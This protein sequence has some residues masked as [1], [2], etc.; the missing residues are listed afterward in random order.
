AKMQAAAD[1]ESRINQRRSQALEDIT[2]AAG[3]TFLSLIAKGESASKAFG[4]V[5]F[6]TV[7]KA[8]PSLVGLIFGQSIA[9]LGPILG[10]IAAG[11][12]TAVF[13]G[14]TELARSAAGLA[15]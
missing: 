9:T 11:A 7:E 1:F 14:L 15:G 2:A 5:V 8:I 10:P 13:I 6:D 12:L 4:K 3:S